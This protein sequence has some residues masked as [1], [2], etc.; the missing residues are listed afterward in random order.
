VHERES[1]GT[2]DVNVWIVKPWKLDGTETVA[3]CERTVDPTSMAIGGWSGGG[4]T[5]ISRGRQNWV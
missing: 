2:E 4:M 1:S 3:P 5:L